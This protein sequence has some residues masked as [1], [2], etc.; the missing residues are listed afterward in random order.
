ARVIRAEALQVNHLVALLDAEGHLVTGYWVSSAGTT[1]SVRGAGDWSTLPI[2]KAVLRSGTEVAATEVIP[3]E[4]LATVGLAEQAFV[5]LL[6][7]PRA[8]EIPFDPREGRAGLALIS[9][10]PVHQDDGATAGLAV[11]FHLFNNDFTLVDQIKEVAAVD[12]ATIFLGDLRVSTNV[13]GL[14][15]KRAIGTRLSKEVTQVVLGQGRPYTGPAF[16]VQEN[17]ITRYDP[18]RN[19][20]GEVIGVLYVGAREARF[21]RLVNSFNERVALVALGTIL[22]TFLL[23]IP[24]SRVVTRPL[25]ELRELAEANRRVARGDM[26]V[27]VPVRAGGDV[28]ELA[29][30]FNTMLDQL[31]ATQDQLV[32]SEKL[33]SLGQLAAGVAHELNNP[34]ATV[35]LFSDILLR[36][37]AP[38]DPRRAD[39]E[40]IVNETR[41]CKGIVAALLDFA[42]QNQVMAQATDLNALVR[43]VLEIEGMR[44]GDAPITMVADLDPQ[45]PIIEADP[46]QLQEVIANLV[47]NAIEAMPSG[48]KLTVRTRPGP[49]GMVTMTVTDTGVGIAPEDQAKL[50]VPFFTTKPVGKGTGLGLAI[51]YGIVKMH[52]GQISVQSQP[53]KGTT[54]TITLPVRLLS[55]NSASTEARKSTSSFL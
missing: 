14:D 21:S 18:V 11:A 37:C 12:T 10:I 45:L 22:A 53:G 33:A 5:P 39:L 49:E 16:V 42:R 38:D 52:R 34:L 8:A 43:Q 46:A 7:T 30:S 20:A 4:T 25:Q 28:G 47:S 17:Y 24:V 31:Q 29:S 2:V 32:H 1:A 23:A 51:V 15:G 55:M 26:T 27:R 19:H 48:G 54:F 50:F 35:L 6:E 36:E 44:L 41:R 13:H 9:V 3:S 40:M